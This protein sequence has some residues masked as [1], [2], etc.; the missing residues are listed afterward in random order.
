MGN[1]APVVLAT[2]FGSDTFV[3]R[4]GN[5]E[6][7]EMTN[8]ERVL[9][10][11]QH[12]QPD[13]TPYHVTFTQKA[14]SAMV[15]HTGDP[16]FEAKLGN[17]FTFLNSELPDG[18]REV[19]PD[20][21]EDEFGVRWDRSI[22]RD[23]GTVC[24][25]PVTPEN[26]ATFP[27]PDP[28]DPSRFES[29]GRTM[30]ETPDGF[31]VVNYGFSLYE[32]AW[33]LAGMEEV[34]TAMVADEKFVDTLLNRILEYNLRLIER[35]CTFDVDMVRFGDDWGQQLGL[36]MGPKLWRKFVKPRIRQMYGLVKARG[37]HVL[38]H[39]CGKVDEV[40]PD[41]IECGL[42]VFNPFQPE[43]M[44]VFEVKRRY[45]R[46]LSFFGGI[47]TQRTLPRGSVAQ[48]RDEVR[49]LLQVVGESGGY[50]A[51]PAHDIPGDARPENVVAMIEVLQSQ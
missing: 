25:R 1:A 23:I 17:C 35:I 31:F 33:T 2:V 8:R 39:S 46:D 7:A 9:A 40:F 16:D 42:D 19:G 43:V 21:W 15:Q 24:N 6:A 12:R 5:E 11:L 20:V 37:K 34:L 48:T 26:V 28:E 51:S 14:H 41:L 27:F 10:T 44:D 13:R 29:Y 32:R 49:K 3:L 45:G 18:W 47:S 22:D 4:G 30:S 36:Q 38:I 50:I